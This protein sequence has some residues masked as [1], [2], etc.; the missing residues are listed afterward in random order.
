[1]RSR[2]RLGLQLLAAAVFVIDSPQCGTRHTDHLQLAVAYLEAERYNRALQEVERARREHGKSSEGALVAALA[3]TGLER[4]DAAVAV[5]AGGLDSAPA[6]ERLHR[7]LREVCARSELYAEALQA[8]E[9]L[10]ENSESPAPALLATVGWLRAATGD[11]PG[12]LQPLQRAAGVEDAETFARLELS[13]TLEALG[14]SAEALEVLERALQEDPDHPEVLL[15]VGLAYVRCDDRD[16]AIDGFERLLENSQQ[17]S[18]DASRIAA[19][20]YEAGSPDLAVRYYERA[21]ELGEVDPFVYNNL[22]WTYAELNTCL[23]R[24]L[25]LARTAVKMAPENPGYLDTYAEV[26]FGLGKIRQA[27]ALMRRA[28]ELVPAGGRNRH[29]LEQQMARFHQALPR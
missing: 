10:L 4:P 25:E 24:A 12:A 7:A 19:A 21:I 1:M 28:L 18:R 5:L 8:V 15:A 17:A 22:A 3:H 2:A 26:Y 23:D 14:R 11:F 9:P 13:R 29:Y 16:A 20:C 6:D 27:V